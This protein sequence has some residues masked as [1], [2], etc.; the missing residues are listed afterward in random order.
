[1]TGPRNR[2]AFAIG[3]RKRQAIREIL[4]SRSPLLPPLTLDAIQAELARRGLYA[5]Q[6]TIAFHRQ[7]I[8]LAEAVKDGSSNYSSTDKDAA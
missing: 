6:S 7:R 3:Q 4:A 1:M 2:V 8:W 5:A